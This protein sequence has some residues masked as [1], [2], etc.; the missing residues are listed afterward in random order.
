MTLKGN[1]VGEGGSGETLFAEI[2]KGE[3]SNQYCQKN[4]AK[5]LIGIMSRA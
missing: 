3:R 1:T 2:M 5:E 4:F